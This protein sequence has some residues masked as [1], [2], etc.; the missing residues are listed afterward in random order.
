MP[1]DP[2]EPWIRLGGCVAVV[3]M[4]MGVNPGGLA[5]GAGRSQD[6]WSDD[7]CGKDLQAACIGDAIDRRVQRLLVS[8]GGAPGSRRRQQQVDRA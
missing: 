4:M 6:W 3:V 7:P 2:Q 8:L 5:G 1:K